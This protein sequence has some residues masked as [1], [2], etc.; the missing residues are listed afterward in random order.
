MCVHGYCGLH[1]H[2]VY[3]PLYTRT[4]YMCVKITSILICSFILTELWE[5]IL[6][7]SGGAKEGTQEGERKETER[8]KNPHTHLPRRLGN[9]SYALK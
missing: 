6:Q 3:V 4:R 5:L 1:I 2:K 7:V 9:L 8:E